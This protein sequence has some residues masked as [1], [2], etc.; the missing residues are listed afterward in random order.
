MHERKTCSES[1]KCY[2]YYYF[3]GLRTKNKIVSIIIPT[4]APTITIGM[5]AKENN[6]IGQAKHPP[7]EL[8]PSHKPKNKQVLQLKSFLKA[9]IRETIRARTNNISTANNAVFIPVLV[10]EGNRFQSDFIDILFLNTTITSTI[11]II[12]KINLANRD[13][14]L[15]TMII[16]DCT[17]I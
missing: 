11:N 1:K 10:Q 16:S 5:T 15:K 9:F 13:R 8:P 17:N 12:S 6:A 7:K 14:L 4:T 3:L 2:L